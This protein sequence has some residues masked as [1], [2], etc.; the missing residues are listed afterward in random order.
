MSKFH[1]QKQIID[2]RSLLV[3]GMQGLAFSVLGARLFYLQSV[4]KDKYQ[5]LS[6][7]NRL[8]IQLI[9]PSRGE[10]TEATGKV[11][12]YNKR[13]FRVYVVKE[14]TK[15]LTEA[16][17]KLSN[18]ISIS[19]ND[20]E[21]TF[22]RAKYRRRFTAVLVRENLN[23]EEMSKISV[24]KIYLKGVEITV[25]ESRLYSEKD[26][27]A[28]VLGYVGKVN[29]GDV[30]SDDDPMLKLP[31]FEIGKT[32]VER[33]YEKLLRGQAGTQQIE[34]NVKGRSIKT[35]DGTA[36]EKG[37]DISL[38]IDD[39]LQKYAMKL[40]RPYRSASMVVLDVKT[41]AVK[42]MVSQPSFDPNLFVRGISNS[43]WG[44]LRD[45]PYRPLTNKSTSGLY[46]PGSLL[47][48][49]VALTA[50]KSN[51]KPNKRV[52]CTGYVTVSK[53]R[54]H[55]WKKQGHGSVNLVRSIRESCD[56]WY[57]EMSLKVGVNNIAKMAK[58]FGLGQTY[59]LGLLT[60][61]KGII[62]NKEWKRNRYD[63]AWYIGE[64]VL[65]SIGQGYV[66]TTPLQLAVMTARIATGKEISPFI[67][68]LDI[69]GVMRDTEYKD[70]SV[71]KE[72][73]DVV[74]QGMYEVVHHRRGTAHRSRLNS[75]AM[76][77]KTGTAQV[78]T[79]SASERESEDGVIKNKDLAWKNRDHA[80]FSGYAPYKNPRFAMCVVVEHGGSGSTTA[81]PLARKIMNEV[82]RLYGKEK[83]V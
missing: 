3:L 18:L 8:R 25:G 41:G 27:Y 69:N 19:N 56:S 32:G 22:K 77:G 70:I 54:F 46:S 58:V 64:T 75:W 61:Y 44:K 47:K 38:T 12:S 15:Q 24:Q 79:I 37:M 20:R 51:I 13:S 4:K 42:A 33:T 40:L 82:E 73:L 14:N 6:E 57:Y 2:R 30:K 9:A 53:R 10:I 65:T 7:R 49:I 36:P 21:M 5:T 34:V 17:D 1:L 63:K 72:H 67:S 60:Q 81:A 23:W 76:A 45:N 48:M 80:L 55:C 50:L 62:P 26:S 52:N 83:V 68:S 74:R 29:L 59:D 66:L 28:H 39:R 11:L 71:P 31:G 43:E 78:R 16:L 35:L